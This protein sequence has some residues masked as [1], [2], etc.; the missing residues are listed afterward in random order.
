MY[1]DKLKEQ[2]VEL[3][4]YAREN[5]T[6]YKNLSANGQATI[7]AVI[8]QGR[9]FGIQEDFILSCARVSAR[10][11]LSIVYSMEESFVAAN[12]T[13]ADGAIDLKNNRII[14]NPEAKSRTGESI[15][16][17]ELTHAIYNTTNGKLKIAKGVETM[18]DTEKERIR[19]RYAQVS[20]GD[21]YLI[22]DEVN[23]HFAEQTLSNKNIL[24]RL[25]EKNPNVKKSILDFFKKAKAEY[26]GDKK[27]SGA[28]ARLYRQ[29]KK[30]FDE[31]FMRNQRYLGVENVSAEARAQ[32]GMKNYALMPY[33]EK[34]KENWKG[35]KSIVIYEN[36]EQ[37]RDFV[38]QSK[39]NKQYSKKMY[40]G[41]IGAELAVRIEAKTGLNLENYNYSLR[42]DEVRK[43]L[44][45]HGTDTTEVPRGQ[46]AVSEQ[47]FLALPNILNDATSIYLS[48]NKYNG[49]PAI[50]FTK[51]SGNEKTTVIAVVS[52]K[53]LDL[54]VQTEYIGI[55]KGI[56]AT[57]L[58][59]QAPNNTP[60]AS[61][62]TDSI[63]IISK[64]SENV[65]PHEKKLGKSDKKRYV[66]AETD[67]NGKQLSDK[68]YEF[69][70]NTAITDKYGN[71]LVLYHQTDADFTMFDPLREGA[72]T[73][74]SETPHGIFMKPTADD[75]GLSGSKQMP[76]YANIQKPLRFIDRTDAQRHWRANIKGY[77]EIINQINANDVRF[78]EQFEEAFNL[79]RLARRK[80]YELKNLDKEQ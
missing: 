24:K 25:V 12:G 18:T 79:E 56:L 38:R 61:S 29:Y 58:G 3:D 70:K 78:N 5:I 20:K 69:F 66:L 67:S 42:A 48:A 16:I 35:S 4:N 19:K 7:R 77:G 76:L 57:Q 23:A 53:H 15:L 41:S 80:K 52:G 13:Y 74:D 46:R 33:N 11:G 51:V 37:L 64:N 43:I 59:E 44:K 47:D 17:H 40:F 8:R 54:R 49:Q 62:G 30:L 60:K 2:A 68:Q 1:N 27:L 63:N 55:K 36:I 71:L 10:S 21:V 14:I 73:R 26:N 9:S 34:Q 75:I 6:D 28:S 50:I 45:D 22:A 65:N 32:V 72:G 31:F 39:E